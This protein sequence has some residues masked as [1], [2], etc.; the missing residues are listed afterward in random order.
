MNWLFYRV[1]RVFVNLYIFMQVASLLIL[2]FV[3]NLFGLGTSVINIVIQVFI[4][5]WILIREIEKFR[6]N[7][8]FE[9]WL[10]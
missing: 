4:N 5:D 10:E 8:E 2:G 6:N 9:E 3:L 7:F 1:P